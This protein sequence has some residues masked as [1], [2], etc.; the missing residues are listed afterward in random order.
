VRDVER[1]ETFTAAYR[2]LFSAAAR[3]AWRM[4]GDAAVA[5]DIAAE[6]MARAYARWPEVHK[7]DAPRAWVMRVATNLAIDTVRR[8]K[9]DARVMPLL[10][11]DDTDDSHVAEDIAVRLALVAALGSLP[12]R[13]REA[14][15]LYYLG[16]L[17]EDEVS[18]SLQITASSVRT[19]VQRG[20][21]ALRKQ[22]HTI[23]G[24]PVR[25][26]I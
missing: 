21:S 8:R 17:S 24:E 12:R 5:E 7:L 23:A 19:H 2:P 22:M 16:G 11:V 1:D 3:L 20:L 26:A 10:A 18:T 15:A 14:I 25:V 9:L 4:T 6:A 13:Q